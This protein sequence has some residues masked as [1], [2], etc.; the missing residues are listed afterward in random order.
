MIKKWQI[1]HLISQFEITGEI[2]KIIKNCGGGHIND[3]HMV[4]IKGKSRANYL[5]QRI[6]HQVFN[7]VPKLMDNISLVTQHIRKKLKQVNNTSTKPFVLV[8][9][10]NGSYY[11]KQGQHYWRVCIYLD[12]SKAFDLVEDPKIAYE[13]GRAFGEFQRY[14]SDL[15]G[16]LLYETIPNFHNIKVRLQNFYTALA[17]NPKN[18]AKNI[19]AEINFIQQ[20]AEEMHLVLTLG[21]KGELPLRVTHN[22]TKFNN[23]LFNQNNQRLCVID[24]D[25]VMPG[26]V[27][28]DYSDCIRT[29]ANTSY[30]DE[31]DLKKVSINMEILEAFTQGFL[32]ELKDTLNTA[33]KASLPY[34]TKLLPFMIGLR[35]LTDYLLGDIYF[36]TQYATQ[37]LVRA[38][39]QFKLTQSILDHQ[40]QIN[41]LFKKLLNN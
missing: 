12:D 10:R 35:F 7:D 37:N 9:A 39:V 14:L 15:P 2:K 29:V 32:E 16:K 19:Q 33:E 26:Y 36:K 17:K 24:L 41:Q 40:Q 1:A 4:K 6:N 21:K 18:R 30:E 22:D 27:H 3:T 38:R 13:G 11:H 8:K 25:T 5:L 31:K 23:V 20:H 28:Y 34:S